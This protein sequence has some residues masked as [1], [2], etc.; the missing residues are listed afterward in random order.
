M[1]DLLMRDAGGDGVPVPLAGRGLVFLGDDGLM[2]CKTH[3][4]QVMALPSGPAGPA[5]E[6][7]LQGESGAGV[8]Q[9]AF[10]DAFL[11]NRGITIDGTPGVLVKR[12]V[13][14][15]AQRLRFSLH[16]KCSNPGRFRVGA[17]LYANGVKAIKFE[18]IAA[19]GAVAN[20]SFCLRAEGVQVGSVMR[21]LLCID[22]S[23][24]AGTAATLGAPQSL[25]YEHDTAG[26]VVEW[27]LG[28]E[29]YANLSALS[30]QLATVKHEVGI[31]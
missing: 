7:G 24:G 23:V 26:A 5:G 16:G 10:T 18:W 8:V 4:G 9:S 11:L 30:W 15:G 21:W 13:M 22:S 1:L 31:A 19:L 20:R 6:R 28:C 29:S 3:D 2:Y 27:G 25:C 14:E 12:E 17:V